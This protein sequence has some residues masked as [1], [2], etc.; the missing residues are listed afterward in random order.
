MQH[1]VFCAHL[2]SL[3]IMSSRFIHVVVNSWKWTWKYKSLSGILTLMLLD[4]YPEVELLDHMVVLFV[5]LGGTSYTFSI[6]TFYIPSKNVQESQFLHIL[7]NIC[8]FAFLV[9]DSRWLESYF[10]ISAPGTCFYCFH[11]S[12]SILLL[13]SGPLGFP[14]GLL[15]THFHNLLENVLQILVGPR[16]ARISILKKGEGVYI[17]PSEETH[18]TFHHHWGQSTYFLYFH[19]Y[20]LLGMQE[21][22]VWFH[23]SPCSCFLPL[24]STTIT[25]V[26]VYCLLSSILWR[27]MSE[28]LSLL[29]PWYSVEWP[30][31]GTHSTNTCPT[32]NP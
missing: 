15:G 30:M 18:W 11:L 27:A 9:I 16:G 6:A 21:P 17:K 10:L 25:C 26:I 13:S 23:N 3:N 31:Q 24:S 12:K 22:C 20:H 8:S 2:I 32:T 14:L 4:E 19:P 7:A 28:F 5:I 1:L 29:Y